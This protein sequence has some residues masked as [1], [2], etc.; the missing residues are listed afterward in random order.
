M[1]Q[2]LR[3]RGFANARPLEL[4]FNALI[5]IGYPMELKQPTVR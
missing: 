4:G 3:Q 1:A 5:A 2:T